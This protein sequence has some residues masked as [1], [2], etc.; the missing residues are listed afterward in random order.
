MLG[1]VGWEVDYLVSRCCPSSTRELFV[2]NL[3]QQDVRTD[4]F[5]EARAQRWFFGLYHEE[6]GDREEVRDA[7]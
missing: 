4:F 2:R 5:G 3:Y 6:H 1:S 7:A